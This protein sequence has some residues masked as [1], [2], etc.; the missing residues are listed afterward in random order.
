MGVFFLIHSSLYEEIVRMMNLL[1]WGLKKNGQKGIKWTR[2]D[3]LTLPKSCGV[4]G[5]WNTEAFNLSIISKQGWKLFNDPSSLFTRNLKAK[6]FPGHDFLE[7]D[8]GHN[9][10]YACRSTWSSQSLATLGYKWKTS[11]NSKID[12]WSMPWI[13]SLT[14]HKPSTTPP[15]HMEDLKA[16]DLPSPDLSSWDP[17][18]IHSIFSFTDA[19]AIL[20]IPL[21]KEIFEIP[22]KGNLYS[23][24]YA[25]SVFYY[26]CS[27]V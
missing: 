22:E 6:Y 17:D 12:A 23:I 11:D 27:R 15:P 14:S 20:S 10:S 7:G 21:Y 18:M 2:L 26:T 5:V 19:V 24:K 8:L 16:R 25:Y 1:C 4:L 13:L 3:K 9:P